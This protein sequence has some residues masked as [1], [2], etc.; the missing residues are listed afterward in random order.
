[1]STSYLDNPEFIDQDTGNSMGLD[2]QGLVTLQEYPILEFEGYSH[3]LSVGEA[4][5]KATRKFVVPQELYDN[6]L[7]DFGG[8]WDWSPS[9]PCTTWLPANWPN[10]PWLVVSMISAVP[11]EDRDYMQGWDVDGLPLLPNGLDVTVEYETRDYIT[12]DDDPAVP[13]G[14]ALKIKMDFGSHAL[15]LSNAGLV[16]D[17]PN[18]YKQTVQPTVQVSTFEPTI[19]LDMEWKWVPLP[20]WASIALLAGSVNINPFFG[21]PIETVMFIGCQ[22]DMAFQTNSNDVMWRLKY[23][24]QV[25]QVTTEASEIGGWNHFFN[26]SPT[27][28]NGDVLSGITY[29]RIQRAADGSPIFDKQDLLDLFGAGNSS[30]FSANADNVNF[31]EQD[32]ILVINDPIQLN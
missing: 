28:K 5:Q 26:P 27:D 2:V 30:S 12:N 25:R 24:F 7:Q 18:G 16:W 15:L 19:V 1:M 9:Q 8:N 14:T 13:A 20:P 22:A 31:Q 21:Y 4:H 23:K 6:F 17:G 32:I 3:S 29:Q 10:K 11:H